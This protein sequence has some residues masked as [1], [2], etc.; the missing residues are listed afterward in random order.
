MAISAALSIILT[1]WSVIVVPKL[2]LTT[3]ASNIKLWI[4]Y[5]F[6]DAS[7]GYFFHMILLKPIRW[8]ASKLP[9][10]NMPSLTDKKNLSEQEGQCNDA[11]IVWPTD[12]MID[13]LPRNWIVEGRILLANE[14]CMPDDI[15]DDSKSQRH[16][17]SRKRRI[18][19]KEKSNQERQSKSNDCNSSEMTHHHQPYYLNHVRGSTRIRQASQRLA[20]ALGT[21][22]SSYI[23]CNLSSQITLEN[24]GLGISSPRQVLFDVSCGF[25]IGSFIVLFIFLLEI[26]MGWIKVVGYWETVVPDENFAFNITWD[27]L[28]HVGVSINE[29]IM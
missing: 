4:I 13:K 15:A 20:L 24:I 8:I 28:F 3:P 9:G 19:T 12:A 25:G 16:S 14:K 29:E 18:S 10:S 17:S 21:L 7:Y 23:L 6:L 1:L 11:T 26:Q 5:M 2:D 27:I 22:T